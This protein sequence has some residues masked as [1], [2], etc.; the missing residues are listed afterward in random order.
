MS[1]VWRWLCLC[2]SLSVVGTETGTTM[3]ILSC[4]HSYCRQLNVETTLQLDWRLGF[5][6][7]TFTFKAN[8]PWMSVSDSFFFF[9]SHLMG[10]CPSNTG[11][12]GAAPCQQVGHISTF[13]GTRWVCHYGPVSHKSTY[14][15]KMQLMALW[16]T[17]ILVIY[18]SISFVLK[19]MQCFL[20][21]WKVN[22]FMG[23]SKVLW[24]VDHM[25]YRMY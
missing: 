6:R 8:C 2:R 5:E 14:I 11:A 16:Q 7:N 13:R 22:I 17:N 4:W 25:L 19:K 15:K 1:H 9:L 18:H 12:L 24:D 21:V 3:G 20:P 10:N 23:T